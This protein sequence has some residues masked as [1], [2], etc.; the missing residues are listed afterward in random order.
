MLIHENL[1]QFIQG[2]KAM[3]DDDFAS[4]RHF[5]TDTR[6]N[7]DGDTTTTRSCVLVTSKGSDGGFKIAAIGE[8]RDK[9]RRTATSWKFVGQIARVGGA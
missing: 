3:R 6:V 9:L 1:K 4:M 5:I 2:L 7:V 8:F